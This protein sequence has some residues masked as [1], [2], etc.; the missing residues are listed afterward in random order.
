MSDPVVVIG[1][2]LAGLAAAARLAKL[3]HRVELY[4]QSDALGG[5]WAPRP[6]AAAGRVAHLALGDPSPVDRPADGPLVDGAPSAI[7]FPAPWRDLFRK[8]GRPLE[9]E[10]ARMGYALEPAPPAAI[11]FADG[12]ELALPTDRGEQY[13]VL[14]AA[15]GRAVADRWRD[16]LDRLVDVWQALRPLGLEAELPARRPLTRTVRARLLGRLTV[17]DLAT[18]LQHPQLG[19]LLRSLAYR[20]GSVPERTPALAAVELAVHRTFGRWQIVPTAERHAADTR[21][22]SVLV[23]ALAARLQLRKVSVRTGVAVRLIEVRDGRAAAVHTDSGAVAA[24]AVVCT[25]D[26][27][28]VVGELVPRTALR[29]TRR[30]LRRLAPAL[31]PVI[32]HRVTAATVPPHPAAGPAEHVVLDPAGVPTVRYVRAATTSTHDFAAGRPDPAYGVAWHGL[33]SWLRRPRVSTELDGLFLAGPCSP[34]GPG[35][36]AVVLSGALASYACDGYL[37]PA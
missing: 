1:G 35:P 30:D 23:D 33:G 11:T 20:A 31:A 9:A 26:P 27:W 14:T 29:R 5:T 13:G 15:Y 16:L 21:R 7:S 18:Q 37:R 34:G 24:A 3:G 6:L 22:S 2:G 17:A 36:S 10:L 4:E 19:A 32:T 8:S 28:R 25:I 12:T